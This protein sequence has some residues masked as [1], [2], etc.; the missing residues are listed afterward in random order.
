MKPM[1]LQEIA[2]KVSPILNKYA[3]QKVWVFGSYARGDAD[4]ASDIDI[5][6]CL[7]GSTVNGLLKFARLNRELEIALG[8]PVDLLSDRQVQP[9]TDKED[10]FSQKVLKERILLRA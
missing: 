8:M 5:I 3:I 9:V 2:K 7:E 4:L 6:V 1:E 10:L